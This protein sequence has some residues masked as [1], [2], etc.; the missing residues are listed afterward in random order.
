MLGHHGWM[1]EFASAAESRLFAQGCWHRCVSR[2]VNIIK[3]WSLA[4][5]CRIDSSGACYMLKC[6]WLRFR[7]PPQPLAGTT[8]CACPAQ[9]L[10]TSFSCKFE[11]NNIKTSE[12]TVN[13]S[14]KR[15]Y[16]GTHLRPLEP[17]NCATSASARR[18]LPFSC[19]TRASTANASGVG[20]TG[21]EL[22]LRLAGDGMNDNSFTTCTWMV[23]MCAAK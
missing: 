15:T 19:R 11:R 14:P 5:F 21:Q 17:Q 1:P 18:L 16:Q 22:Q 9:L 13:A 6:H 8:P 4:H 2:C 20:H 3:T 7:M 12:R 10:A 23:C